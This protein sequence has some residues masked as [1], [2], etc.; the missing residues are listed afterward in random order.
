MENQYGRAN[1][2]RL[3]MINIGGGVTFP[4]GGFL[5]TLGVVSRILYLKPE[6]NVNVFEDT[7]KE[8]NK[9]E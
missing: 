7:V 9:K 5:V 6:T 2:D 8:K 1:N 4:R 3:L